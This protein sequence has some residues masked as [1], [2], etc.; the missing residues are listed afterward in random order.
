MPCK[1]QNSMTEGLHSAWG[2]REQQ[3]QEI[4][5]PSLQHSFHFLLSI[6]NDLNFPSQSLLFFRKVCPR[7]HTLQP[8]PTAAAPCHTL[9][10]SQQPAVGLE[11][12]EALWLVQHF[13]RGVD[14]TELPLT[15]S[16]FASPHSFSYSNPSCFFLM[17]SDE[18]F[19]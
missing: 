8:P 7:S 16:C 6:L 5:L 4:P 2:Q 9:Q 15:P 17:K 1:Y 3:C 19:S 14:G 10:G 13:Q 12:A 18:L 11:K